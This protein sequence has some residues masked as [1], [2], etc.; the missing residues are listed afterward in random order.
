MVH[1]GEIERISGKVE[2]TTPAPNKGLRHCG[3]GS[4]SEMMMMMIMKCV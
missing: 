3:G 4:G 2:L 1:C